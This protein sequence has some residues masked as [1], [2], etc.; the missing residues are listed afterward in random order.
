MMSLLI[1]HNYLN[2]LILTAKMM[3]LMMNQNMN[4]LDSNDDDDLDDESDTPKYTE[5]NMPSEKTKQKRKTRKYAPKRLVNVNKMKTI[6]E[7]NLK[8]CPV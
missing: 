3:I 7:N 6:F 8:N 1:Y 2:A 5:T 4:D